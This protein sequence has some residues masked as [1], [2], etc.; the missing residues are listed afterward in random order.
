MKRGATFAVAFTTL[1]TALPLFA[2][3][4]ELTTLASTEY[5][6]YLRSPSRCKGGEADH[7]AQAGIGRWHEWK[8]A[9]DHGQEPPAKAFADAGLAFAHLYNELRCRDGL[10]VYRYGNLLRLNESYESGIRILESSLERIRANYPG[11]EKTVESTLGQA[12]VAAG[13]HDDAIKH[14]RRVLELDLH[15]GGARLD[16]ANQLF[17]QGD[18][19]GAREQAEKALEEPLSEHGQQIAVELIKKTQ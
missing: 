1:M 19:A 14:Y 3:A 12:C 18:K 8:Y 15:D 9:I 17:H 11:L 5:L 4:D 2:G 10:M 16:L 13:R 7:A 6:A